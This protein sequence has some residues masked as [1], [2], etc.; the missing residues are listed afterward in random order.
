MKRIEKAYAKIN[1]T[2]DVVG[3]RP[4]G[5]HDIESVMQLTDLWDRITLE[6]IE[7]TELVIQ[8]NASF[9][10]LDKKN[11]CHKAATAFFQAFR[12]PPAGFAI[13]IE[14]HIPVAA[15]LGGGSAD[16]AAVIRLLAKEYGICDTSALLA[17]A[18]SVGSDVPFCLVGGARICRGRGEL[19]EEI[20]SSPVPMHLV[21]AKNT[22]GLSTPE[23][24]SLFDGL[25][26]V[27][28][29]PSLQQCVEALAAG[30]QKALAASI[31]NVMEAVSI[32]K[33]PGIRLLKDTMLRMGAMGAMMSGSGPS[34]FGL[35]ASQDRARACRDALRRKKIIAHTATTMNIPLL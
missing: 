1:L 10:P 12:L 6:K 26:S 27:P 2:L 30:D 19:M 31:F 7:G 25:P 3:R 28:D 14:K 17:V 23:I 11:I 29:H 9:L 13:T 5:F 21:I 20:S 35:F 32:P 8:S 15:G 16:G 34:V 4:D 33:R 18:A 24:Y 22:S